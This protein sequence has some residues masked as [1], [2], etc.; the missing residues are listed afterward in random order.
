ML[1]AL[2]FDKD[3]GQDVLMACLK[4]GLWVNRVKPN[5]LRLMPA[6]VIGKK[7]VD[8][9]VAILDGVLSRVK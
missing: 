5:T 4:E 7:E 1:A 2:E 9:A 8:E 3:I 6:L